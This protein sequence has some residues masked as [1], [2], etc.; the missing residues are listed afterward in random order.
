MKARKMHVDIQDFKKLRTDGYVYVDKTAFVHKLAEISNAHFLGKK[1]LFGGGPEQPRLAIA[2]LE[3]DWTAYPAF[4]IDLVGDLNLE[5]MGN[6]FVSRVLPTGC[7]E[8][9]RAP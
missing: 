6:S 9:H 7:P 3:T 2:D 8:T 1:E 4:H 5:R